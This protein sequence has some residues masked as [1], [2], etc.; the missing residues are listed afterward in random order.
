MTTSK[1]ALKQFS[2]ILS[3]LT[4]RGEFGHRLFKRS[5][6]FTG[7]IAMVKCGVC[8]FFL[9]NVLAF[10]I[11]LELL[12]FSILLATLASSFSPLDPPQAELLRNS[13]LHIMFQISH[14]PDSS[15]KKAHFYFS[16]TCSHKNNS[17]T[18]SAVVS[19]P[20]L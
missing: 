9:R 2:K 12:G 11:M 4:E 17:R 8:V 5:F 19:R 16:P 15:S 13:H 7:L 18:T 20:L 3:F 14:S 6:E 1:N 10:Q